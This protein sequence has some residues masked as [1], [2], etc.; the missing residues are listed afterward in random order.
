VTSAA[1][2]RRNE[3][4]GSPAQAV[5][6]RAGPAAAPARV[7]AAAVSGT[8]V[9]C[10]FPDL[11]LHWLLW[12][13]LVP[14]MLALDGTRRAFGG[15]LLGWIAG[16][17][18]NLGGFYWMSYMLEEF[19][20]LPPW[21]AWGVTVLNAA[22]QGLVFGLFGYL[23]V[24]LRRPGIVHRLVA[25]PSFMVLCEAAVPYVFPWY[26]SNGLQPQTEV[27]QI[28]EII[29]VP[30]ASAVVVAVNA[31][32]A[33]AI[34]DA[35]LAR[36]APVMAVFLAVVVFAS[37][38]GFGTL[39]MAHI[40]AKVRVAPTLKVA[41]V[42]ADVGI[43]EK[44]SRGLSSSERQLS[45]RANLLKHQV[46]SAEAAGQGAE[47]IVWPESSYMPFQATGI[48]R[49]DVFGL[50]RT[51][52][53]R[54]LVRTPDG[55][56]V[57]PASMTGGEVFADVDG[58]IRAVVG[59]RED[60]AMV[61]VRGGRIFRLMPE[62]WR[63]ELSGV[64]L[65]LNAGWAG[66]YDAFRR[67]HVR[68]LARLCA[69]DEGPCDLPAVAVGDGGTWLRR[70]GGRWERV[71]CP[72]DRDLLAVSG[73]WAGDLYAVGTEGVLLRDDGR[74][75]TLLR[76][77]GPTLRAVAT[78]R[79]GRVA[80]VGDDCTLLLAD[81][82]S[83]IRTIEV[84][85]CDERLRSVAFLPGGKL[86]AGGRAGTLL[87]E[88]TRGGAIRHRVLPGEPYLRSLDLD[89]WG[90]MAAGLGDGLVLDLSEPDRAEPPAL[91]EVGEETY[92]YAHVGFLTDRAIPD[93]TRH[94]YA[95]PRP[96]PEG[97]SYRER[98]RRDSGT[99]VLDRD[100][101]QRGFATHLLFGAI[102]YDA[103]EVL[104]LSEPVDKHLRNS[105]VL[106]DPTGRV[107]G[108][109]HKIRLLIFGEYLPFEDLI[110]GLRELVPEAGFFREGDG[111]RVLSMRLADGK[112]R[113]IAPLVCYED[114]IPEFGRIMSSM[115][116]DLLVNVTN[117]AWFGHT[118]EPALHL[119]LAAA[120]AVESRR[121]LVRSTNTGI[122]AFVDPA[123]RILDQTSLS[124][125]EV[126]VRALPLLEAGSWHGLIERIAFWTLLLWAILMVIADIVRAAPRR[127]S[128]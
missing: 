65:N 33:R 95:S 46:L 77:G 15:F 20:H 86:I 83:G 56:F 58:R 7:I 18:T 30:A 38:F 121:A 117:D 45:L 39:R 114:V 107:E 104:A 54:L 85:G 57:S 69:G 112:T 55:D 21:G 113:R 64:A 27:F 81:G 63:E 5:R 50:V 23:Y 31:L 4:E 115:R 60:T 111:V 80:A 44:E 71:S 98:A 29:G 99:D 124:D 116:H 19:G 22:W 12:I 87:Y 74:T 70:V 119:Q 123:G 82:V 102:T 126:R 125:P 49:S 120:R 14:L 40:D 88:V 100:A 61:L 36:R 16:T 75:V 110:P 67:N 62:G 76:Q 106:L 41:M 17:V 32:L 92:R 35:V 47:L 6:R 1:A 78:H 128:R 103:A 26:L 9:F 53:N 93:D 84:E 48:K 10:A 122:S 97:G 42:E 59:G 118:S 13:G 105:V 28:V 8:M 109:S 2:P 91:A 94:I 127:G 52:D 89:P 3:P 101:V 25:V 43:W 108:V 11:Q 37:A 96:M 24:R 73:L 90:R 79:S 72:T 66:T 34:R 51:R 68:A